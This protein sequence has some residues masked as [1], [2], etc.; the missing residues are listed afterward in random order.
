MESTYTIGW[1]ELIGD[2]KMNDGMPSRD[3]ILKS[4]IEQAKAVS[5]IDFEQLEKDGVI[6]KVKGGYLVK[7]DSQL[8]FA[9][10]S[11]MKSMKKTKDGMQMVI[12]KPSA[13]TKKLASK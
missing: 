6:E 3:E 9:A 12:G 8:P 11:L 7:K 5:A 10:K 2:F 4:L 1:W 13:A